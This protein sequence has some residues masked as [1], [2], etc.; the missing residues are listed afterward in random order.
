MPTPNPASGSKTMKAKLFVPSGAF[1][2]DNCGE[3]FS[4]LQFGPRAAMSRRP[5]S[6]AFRR[7]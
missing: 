2:H 6:A 5:F 7:P 4:P 1:D 3:T